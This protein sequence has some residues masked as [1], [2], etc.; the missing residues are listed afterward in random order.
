MRLS[1][2]LAF[3]AVLVGSAA[4]MSGEAAADTKLY[5]G[6]GCEASDPSRQSARLIG[7]NGVLFN[8]DT[9]SDLRVVCPLVKDATRIGSAFVR[10]LDQSTAAD[11]RCT[12]RTMRSDGSVQ[13]EQSVGTTGFSS[14]VQ[15]LSFAGQAAQPGNVGFYALDCTLPARQG[16]NTSAVVM[17]SVTEAN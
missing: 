1:S 8:F 16:S 6:V 7:A 14:G 4:A 9:A 13:Q 3:S 5:P 10:V 11:V 12:L 2:I 17:I 15:Q